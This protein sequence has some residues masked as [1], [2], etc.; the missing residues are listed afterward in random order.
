M[1]TT[2]ACEEIR[3]KLQDTLLKGLGKA[4]DYGLFCADKD[5]SKKG[6]WLDP[7]RTLEYYQFENRVGRC[8]KV[9]MFLY[10]PTN[11]FFQ[12][13]FISKFIFLG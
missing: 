1:T 11:E 3:N 6:F 12:R 7:A 4:E 13:M 5:D 10:I 2:E 9:L 8:V